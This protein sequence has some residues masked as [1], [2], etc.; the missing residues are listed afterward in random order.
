MH[1]QHVNVYMLFKCT[2]VKQK[3]NAKKEMALKL[4]QFSMYAHNLYTW[5][6]NSSHILLD[7]N[8]TCVCAFLKI[9]SLIRFEGSSDSLALSTQIQS[10]GCHSRIIKDS[11]VR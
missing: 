11:Q 7:N 6:A 5:K 9:N 4:I 2:S 8:G 10:K 3:K 1:T